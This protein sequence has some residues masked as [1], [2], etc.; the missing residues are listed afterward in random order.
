MDILYQ[1]RARQASFSAGEG[2]I[3]KL[4]LSDIAFAAS[5]SLDELASRAEVSSATLSRFARN[6]GCRDL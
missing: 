4:L 1:I 3:A 2:R 5:A 6:I